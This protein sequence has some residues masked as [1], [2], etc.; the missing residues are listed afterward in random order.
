MK[1]DRAQFI[2]DIRGLATQNVR[3]RHQGRDPATGLDCIHFARWGYEKQGLEIPAELASAFEVY[4]DQPDGR[5]LLARMRQ[6]L[7]EVSFEESQ[8]ADIFIEYIFRNPKHLSIKVTN[9]APPMVV[10]AT[11]T[12][13]TIQGRIIERPFDPRRR[14]AGVFRIPDFA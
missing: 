12:P 13:G 7:I 2:S 8:P 10:E 1:L 4:T 14:I 9:D 6:W 5:I 11:R 3:F